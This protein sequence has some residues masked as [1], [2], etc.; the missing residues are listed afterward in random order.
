MARKHV[1][2]HVD[3]LKKH[4][5]KHRN[6]IYKLLRKVAREDH[7]RA[8][9]MMLMG[10]G[11]SRKLKKRKKLGKWASGPIPKSGWPK[12]P[13]G[14]GKKAGWFWSNVSVKSGSSV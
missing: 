9:S 12:K 11:F 7:K 2:K 1:K 3:R 6:H 4:A 10:A 8:G 14:M 13:V 5:T